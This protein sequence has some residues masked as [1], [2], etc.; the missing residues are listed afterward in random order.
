MVATAHPLTVRLPQML[1]GGIGFQSTSVGPQFTP[2]G[3]SVFQATDSVEALLWRVPV[4]LPDVPQWFPDLLEAV[5]GMRFT[6]G[7]DLPAAVAPER[8]LALRQQLVAA[9]PTDA[10]TLWARR[11]LLG[12]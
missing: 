12:K 6:A 1:A 9:R 3:S 2:N 4:P 8:F 11:W 5:A 10:Y 7:T